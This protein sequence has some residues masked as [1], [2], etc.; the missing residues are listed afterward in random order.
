MAY[1]HQHITAL[2]LML[3]QT[4]VLL[5]FASA[6]AHWRLGQWSYALLHCWASIYDHGHG[7]G[8]NY[9]GPRGSHSKAL[10]EGTHALSLATS[11]SC[12]PIYGAFG[13]CLYIDYKYSR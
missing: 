9:T 3:F 7:G 13:T 8:I 5:I 6:H 4:R 10:L 2:W 1:H 11:Q 12:E